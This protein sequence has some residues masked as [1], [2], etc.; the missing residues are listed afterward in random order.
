MKPD[1]RSYKALPLYV[2]SHK[3]DNIK[4]LEDAE[5][6][7]LSQ[8]EN[9]LIDIE[10]YNK[11]IEDKIH[12]TTFYFGGTASLNPYIPHYHD[13]VFLILFLSQL[14]SQIFFLLRKK[15][16]LIRLFVPTREGPVKI[17]MRK[18]VLDLQSDY[19]QLCFSYFVFFQ[20]LILP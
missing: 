13:L 14:F 8:N 4:S 17:A 12:H 3:E 1:I 7:Y 11:F 19:L 18:S 5:K 2:L 16:K 6:A 20:L 9:A 10:S 15:L